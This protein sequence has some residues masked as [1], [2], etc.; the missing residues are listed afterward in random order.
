MSI[1]ARAVTATL[2]ALTALGI[3]GCGGDEEGAIGERTRTTAPGRTLYIYSSLR[4]APYREKDSMYKAIRLA[5]DS[6]SGRAGE[7]AI[8]WRDLDRST[9]ASGRWTPEQVA[10]DARTA[11][12]DPRTIGYI[13]EF[14]SAA[15]RIAIPILNN[16]NI[17]VVSPASTRVGLTTD[18]DPGGP[19]SDP[20]RNYPNDQRTF[21][22]LVPRDTVQAA[23]LVATMRR[24]GCKRTA[25]AAD[26]TNYGQSLARLLQ[27]QAKDSGVGMLAKVDFTATTN[28]QPLATMF[29]QEDAGCFVLAAGSSS[30]NAV[31]L[32]RSVAS[33]LGRSARLYGT[34]ELCHR[35]FTSP[36]AGLPTTVSRRFACVLPTLPVDEYGAAAE[37]FQKAYRRRWRDE[38][39]TPYAIYAY[40]AMKLY[41][42]TIEAMGPLAGDKVAVNAA[43]HLTSD[44][45]SVLGPY[46][47][48]ANGDVTTSRYGLYRVGPRG[49]PT[50]SG[51]V[52][53]RPR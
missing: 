32:Y 7:F 35:D 33:T 53:A 36:G 22:R 11:T 20:E 5:M 4:G 1:S 28:A 19:K 42:D 30:T 23:A 10:R 34:G 15:S 50:F 6:V 38:T 40:E 52:E 21:A 44:R 45:R 48:D 43:I 37:A 12:T 2:M 41:L 16:A 9:S 27:A 26:G 3:A 51:V 49:I 31:R 47:F 14:A 13:G 24:D 39:P 18:D 46:S 17:P 25:L 29:R 8:E